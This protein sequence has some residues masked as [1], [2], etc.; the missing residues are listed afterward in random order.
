MA[1]ETHGQSVLGISGGYYRSTYFDKSETPHFT[2]T[3]HSPSTYCLNAFL[4]PRDHRYVN[5]GAELSFVHK[6]LDL[7]ITQGG[8]G[9]RD[10]YLD[11]LNLNY[12]YNE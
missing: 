12:L 2:G 7:E 9:S 6:I 10:Y 1:A 5:V 11:H 4:K 3:Y 8:L